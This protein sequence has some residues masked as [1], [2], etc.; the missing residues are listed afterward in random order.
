MAAFRVAI[1]HEYWSI[2]YQRADISFTQARGNQTIFAGVMKL[3]MLNSTRICFDPFR[4][5]F[6]A[7][8]V[9]V[10]H[11]ET[12]TSSIFRK[13]LDE[14]F[15]P[16]LGVCLSCGAIGFASVAFG[17]IRCHSTHHGQFTSL[18]AGERPRL[19]R[20]VVLNMVLNMVIGS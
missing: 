18:G 13:K 10:F 19:G 7:S 1:P 2:H 9:P 4:Q 15:F 11:T 17:G 6:W 16:T 14:K 5:H 12:Q 8:L 3:F 20:G